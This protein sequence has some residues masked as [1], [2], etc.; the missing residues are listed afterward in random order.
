[1][2]YLNKTDIMKAVSMKDVIDAIDKAY[3]IYQS[4]HFQMPTRMQVT[5]E[6]NTL[7]L[8]PCL[9]KEAIGT[10]LIT[11]FPKNKQHP[12]L[13][14]LVILN[15]QENGQIKALIDGSF[16]TAFRTGAIGGSAIRHLA[17]NDAATLAIIGTGVQ[18]LYQAVAAC[19]VRSI[20]DIYL[21][22]RT[23][24]KIPSFIKSLQQ[25]IDSSIKIHATESAEEAITR[26]EIIITATTSRVPVLPDIPELLANKLIIGIG[27]FQP[28][29]RE[30]PRSLFQLADTIIVDTEDAIAESGDIIIPLEKNW[31][32]HKSIQTMASHITSGNQIQDRKTI[33]F[34]STGMA[35]FDIVVTDLIYQRALAK[36]VGQDLV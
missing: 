16:I 3:E 8:M 26:A 4:K 21:Y 18:G 17:K 22:N 27:S 35:L 19:T 14:G 28:F 7:L 29:M 25:M 9:T 6:E 30:F 15:S 13:H 5:D 20:T 32:T 2:F 11:S 36:G 12:V 23:F 24:D 31:I 33:V 34:K 10:K 1:M